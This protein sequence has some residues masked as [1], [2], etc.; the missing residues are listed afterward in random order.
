MQT[1]PQSD[2]L[3]CS[4]MKVLLLDCLVYRTLLQVSEASPPFSWSERSYRTP[5]LLLT[6]CH[7]TFL[8]ETCPAEYH[9]VP[10]FSRS[11]MNVLLLLDYLVHRTI[12]RMSEANP[13]CSLGQKDVIARARSLLLISFHPIVATNRNVFQGKPL[14]NNDS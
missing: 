10:K 1:L 12:L 7:T 13:L 9:T 14:R 3:L 11:R 6:S 8:A 5:S 4:Q 2:E